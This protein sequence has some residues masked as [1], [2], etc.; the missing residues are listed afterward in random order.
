MSAYN[1]QSVHAVSTAD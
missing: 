1:S